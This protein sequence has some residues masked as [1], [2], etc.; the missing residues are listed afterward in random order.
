[1][2]DLKNMVVDVFIENMEE[3]ENRSVLFKNFKYVL[4]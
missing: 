4:S 2:N 1:M 3:K